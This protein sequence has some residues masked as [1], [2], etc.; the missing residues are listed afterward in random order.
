MNV[1]D[2]IAHSMTTIATGG[3]STYTNS[4]GHFDSFEIELVA[5][6]FII[7]GSIP[8]LS[9]IKFIKGDRLIFF[10]LINRIQGFI[11]FLFYLF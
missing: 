10:F 7:M 4:F 8:F 1:F 2:S 6:I 9:Y 5:I 11:F 3:F